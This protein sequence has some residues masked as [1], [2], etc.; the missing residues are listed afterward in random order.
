LGEVDYS[1][2]ALCAAHRF[3]WASLILL[4]AAADSFPRFLGAGS[5]WASGC[6][7]NGAG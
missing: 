2:M 7:P 5:D 1:D 3:F 4:R 6:G